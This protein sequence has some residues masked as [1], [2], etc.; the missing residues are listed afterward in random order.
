M[1][2][3][4]TGLSSMM[5]RLARLGVQ[6]PWIL[7]AAGAA[8]LSAAG[9]LMLAA[10]RVAKADPTLFG[11]PPEPDG[12]AEPDGLA[13]QA[14]AAIQFSG[15][16]PALLVLLAVMLLAACLVLTGALPTTVRINSGG[17]AQPAGR[18]RRRR[19]LLCLATVAGLL[20]LTCAATAALAL[21]F[22]S[23]VLKDTPGL[24]SLLR[25]Y[26]I[27]ALAVSVAALVL[28]APVFLSR[29]A[30]GPPPA[31]PAVQDEHDGAAASP[32]RRLSAQSAEEYAPHTPL[33]SPPDLIEG[34]PPLNRE[35]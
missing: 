13:R 23:P 19:A 29:W 34:P 30:P 25:S 33:S 12:S 11:V 14:S 9:S 28:L 1:A 4:A 22:D 16:I 27:T 6:W 32:T 20:T 8:L 5:R 31:S 35:R 10:A 18:S 21:T 26:S 7:L 24:Q 15:P 2:G 3:G 17:S